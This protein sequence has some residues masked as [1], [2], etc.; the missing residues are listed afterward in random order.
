MSATISP[1]RHGWHWTEKPALPHT[2]PSSCKVWCGPEGYLSLGEVVRRTE[3]DIAQ[4]A[5]TQPLRWRQARCFAP[6]WGDFIQQA[7]RKVTQSLSNMED[8]S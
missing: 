4:Y 6:K 5:A 2:A 1:T 7:S 8:E 3:R